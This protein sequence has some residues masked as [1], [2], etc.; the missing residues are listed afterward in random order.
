MARL[1]TNN[2]LEEYG[3]TI[4]CAGD[5][6]SHIS[7]HI[8]PKL[9]L[10]RE[11]QQGE[12]G[13]GNHVYPIQLSDVHSDWFTQ[14]GIHDLLDISAICRGRWYPELFRRHSATNLGP[15]QLT[16]LHSLSQTRPMF[17]LKSIPSWSSPLDPMPFGSAGQHPFPVEI[18]EYIFSLVEDPIQYSV[19]G[20]QTYQYFF[21]EEME[22]HLWDLD[23]FS[24]NSTFY[25]RY[26][27][28]LTCRSWYHMGIRSLW[29]HIILNG[30][31]LETVAPKIYDAL[32]R[33]PVRGAYTV[34]F[35]VVRMFDYDLGLVSGLISKILSFLTN[36]SVLYCPVQLLGTLPSSFRTNTVVVHG[37]SVIK[38]RDSLRMW[39]SSFNDIFWRH[40]QTLCLTS[41][42]RVLDYAAYQAP[43][44]FS[45][46]VHLRIR[47]L[48][49][50]IFRWITEAW[51]LPV[52][53]SLSMILPKHPKN[54]EIIARINLI[55][56]LQRVRLKLERIQVPLIYMFSD[57]T[58]DQVELPKLVGLHLLNLYEENINLLERGYHII[59]AP[60]LRRFTFYAYPDQPHGENYRRRLYLMHTKLQFISSSIKE[61]DLIATRG[62]WVG[63]RRYKPNELVAKIE[64]L[65]PW[66]YNNE[67]VRIISGVKG[68]V[69][70][71]SLIQQES[72]REKFNCRARLVVKEMH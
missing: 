52:L 9:K 45:N 12:R 51:H 16:R 14:T 44:I 64:H 23:T 17:L 68:E 69:E 7:R 24:G 57:N 38:S 56:L 3:S 21:S 29:S 19:N 15:I 59:K 5:Q 40:C 72:Y 36:L 60:N 6:S 49:A 48:E 55:P 32:K 46:L 26:F 71:F 25:T 8:P 58:D 4:M 62:E 20:Y 34:R 30:T 54:K 42:L 63:S 13:S 61:I 70:T 10:S 53:K 27:I 43:V 66:I 22:S 67:R 28:V 11:W 47:I 65:S 2:G 31:N 37:H 18:W 35:S 1:N 41:P 33:I 39:Q 50:S